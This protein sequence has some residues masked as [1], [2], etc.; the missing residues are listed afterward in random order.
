MKANRVKPALSARF[1][2]ILLERIKKKKRKKN[3]PLPRKLESLFFI[4]NWKTDSK[5]P[6]EE[7]FQFGSTKA[8]NCQKFFNIVT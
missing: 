6:L 2:E 1:S 7:K 4:V 5:F 3:L 8:F